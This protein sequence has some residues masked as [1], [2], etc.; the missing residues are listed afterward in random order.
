MS[1]TAADSNLEAIGVVRDDVDE[2]QQPQQCGEDDDEGEKATLL[3]REGVKRYDLLVKLIMVGQSGVGK[4]CL[5]RP[6][7]RDTYFILEFNIEPRQTFVAPNNF[8]VFSN[9]PLTKA[10][11]DDE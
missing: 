2:Q 9:R 3:L 11:V 7:N 5:K 1:S 10:F 8:Q 6:L 4:V